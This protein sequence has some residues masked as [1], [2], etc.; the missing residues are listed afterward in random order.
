MKTNKYTN[1]TSTSNGECPHHTG[2]YFSIPLWFRVKNMF[3][4]DLCHEPIELKDLK[5]KK[6]E[7]TN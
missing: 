7:K 4:C 1:T 2:W 3:W 6:D 5:T